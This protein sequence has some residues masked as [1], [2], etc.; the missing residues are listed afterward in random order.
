MGY[1]VEIGVPVPP[2][3][4]VINGKVNSDHRTT[5]GGVQG[6]DLRQSDVV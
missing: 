1:S 6:F 4:T 5:D 2:T 3:G